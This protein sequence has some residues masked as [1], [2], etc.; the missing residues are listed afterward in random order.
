MAS[1]RPTFNIFM[2]DFSFLFDHVRP[3]GQQNE[4]QK[5]YRILSLENNEHQSLKSDKISF[6]VNNTTILWCDAT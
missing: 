3:S 5:C 2:S 6:R 4:K 1:A